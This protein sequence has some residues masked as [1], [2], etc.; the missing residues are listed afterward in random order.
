[1]LTVQCARLLLSATMVLA[2]R[3]H[4]FVWSVFAPKLAY[5]LLETIFV[6]G[7]C[8]VLASADRLAPRLF[9]VRENV[10]EASRQTST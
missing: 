8:V 3:H 5:E 7:V 10:S 6:V 4:L 1:M 2:M 9:I